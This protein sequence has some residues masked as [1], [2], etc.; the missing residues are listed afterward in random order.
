MWESRLLKPSSWTPICHF[1]YLNIS[2]QPPLTVRSQLPASS[3]PPRF[4]QLSAE[5]R[6]RGFFLFVCLC[7]WLGQIFCSSFPACPLSSLH[8][9]AAVWWN[10][11]IL[12]QPAG[13][14]WE[15][16]FRPV[17]RIIALH[18]CWERT[19]QLLHWTT[20][21]YSFT[22]HWSWMVLSYISLRYF[23]PQF[24]NILYKMTP[25]QQFVVLQGV[26]NAVTVCYFLR[27]CC[28]SEVSRFGAYTATKIPKTK[29][30]WLYLATRTI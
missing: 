10:R 30:W 8:S 29:P 23:M 14:Q 24:Y 16:V 22:Y 5:S 19:W 17:L 6:C 2:N 18:S 4:F 3:A 9:P 1:S 12:N 28:H 26:K 25:K 15:E 27:S 21:L 7:V 13:W 11:L 20:A